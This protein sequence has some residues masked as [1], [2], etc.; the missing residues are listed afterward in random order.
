MQR[1]STPTS[2]VNSQLLSGVNL[3]KSIR[4]RQMYW[5]ISPTSSPSLQEFAAQEFPEA[6]GMSVPHSTPPDCFLCELLQTSGVHK[7]LCMC[8]RYPER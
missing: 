6:K 5:V 2:P 7:V 3:G 4:T 8:E 1:L